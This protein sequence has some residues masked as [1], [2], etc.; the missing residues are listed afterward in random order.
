MTKL[1]R[2]GCVACVAFLCE[3]VRM[4]SGCARAD[5]KLGAKQGAGETG[6][7]AKGESRHEIVDKGAV[8]VV[9]QEGYQHVDTD[10]GDN[11]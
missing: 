3:V 10:W 8:G 4:M 9:C 6:W 11:S 1:G 5:C 7:K 2:V